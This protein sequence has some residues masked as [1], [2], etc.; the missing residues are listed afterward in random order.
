MQL[1][2]RFLTRSL[3]AA[4]CLCFCAFTLPQ[5]AFAAVPAASDRF[6]LFVRSAVR[7]GELSPDERILHALNR[8]T[9]GPRSGDLAA[10]KGVGL[11]ESFAQQLHPA[12]IDNSGLQVRLAEYPAMQWSSEDILA[13]LPS[14]AVIR[15]VIDGKA[16]MPASGAVHTVYVNQVARVSYRREQDK[17]KQQTTANATP[18]TNAAPVASAMASN[19]MSSASA[20]PPQAAASSMNG[21]AT[22][23]QAGS[24]QGGS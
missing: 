4:M 7:A 13:R 3:A 12:S 2:D 17:L 10:V 14:G 18:A 8:F 11:D 15:Q 24:A 9:F 6:G 21:V 5:P 23:G 20:Q 19:A 1:P 22:N 16:A